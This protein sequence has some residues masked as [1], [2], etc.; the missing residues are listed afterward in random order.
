MFDIDEEFNPDNPSFSA[1]GDEFLT[2]R[3]QVRN[4][5]LHSHLGIREPAC[6]HDRQAESAILAAACKR[7]IED[8]LGYTCYSR[9]AP[10]YTGMIRYYGQVY[11]RTYVLRAVDRLTMLGI[12]HHDLA[13]SGPNTTW[14]SRFRLT[15]ET[16]KKRFDPEFVYEIG[17][18][19]L[20]RDDDRRLIGYR[21]TAETRRM[22]FEVANCNE[23]IGGTS[24]SIGHPQIVQ[25]GPTLLVPNRDGSSN[26]VSLTQE[27]LHRIFCNG[28]FAYGG[29][30]YRVWWQSV[31][32]FMRATIVIGGSDTVELDY[33]QLHPRLLYAMAGAALVGD[34]YTL[35]GWPRGIGKVAFNVL[36][37]ARSWHDATGAVAKA[38]QGDAP[39]MPSV[40]AWAQAA[41]LVEAMKVRHK[42]VAAYF[43]SGVG[44]RLQRLDSEMA[45][46]TMLRL[47]RQGI[48]S[49]PVH[50][51]FIVE[52][53]YEDEL[54][55]AMEH[56]YTVISRQARA[57]PHSM[58]PSSSII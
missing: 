36:V 15:S 53:S 11:T 50:D 18:V 12:L 45:L 52:H 48:V 37:N 4:V 24:I 28:T 6:H 49:L 55:E 25:I 20:L 32:K 46:M 34:A 54:R 16:V 17:E 44:V 51:S 27:K 56:A 19:I 58:N 10:H 57:R 1:R 43:H 23:A 33:S 31:P 22:R 42:Q 21:D 29:R 40:I 2:L 41:D 7:W 35:N 26:V 5:C 39:D 30:F 8:P 47:I 14:Q 3:W 13:P 38:I 9:R